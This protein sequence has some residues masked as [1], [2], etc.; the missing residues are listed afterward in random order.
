MHGKKKLSK[1][2]NDEKLS[3]IDKEKIW[4]L[5]S[6]NKIVWVINHRSDNR[7][8]VSNTTNNI[9]KIKTIK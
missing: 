4:L 9:L 7:F 5:C 8:S 6:E 3:L 2:F 1:Y